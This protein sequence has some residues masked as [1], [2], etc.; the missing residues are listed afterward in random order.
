MYPPY[1]WLF[2]FI[3][4]YKQKCCDISYRLELLFTNI[5]QNK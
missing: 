2:K 1:Q 4:R 5:I 3:Q